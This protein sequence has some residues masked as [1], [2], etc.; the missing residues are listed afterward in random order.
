MP[1][2]H[3]T[4]ASPLVRRVQGKVFK[5]ARAGDSPRGFESLT[6]RF[7]SRKY[8]VD[9]GYTAHGIGY[10]T[11]SYFQFSRGMDRE[12]LARLPGATLRSDSVTFSHTGSAQPGLDAA[13]LLK[14]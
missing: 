8:P 5:T 3:S 7:P 9:P 6:L 10:L 1:R 14:G 13:R 2:L 4:V 11:P 12:R